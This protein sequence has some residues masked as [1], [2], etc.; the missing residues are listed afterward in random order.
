M[1]WLLTVVWV[2]RLGIYI[3]SD[4]RWKI[5]CEMYE[6]THSELPSFFTSGRLER[7]CSGTTIIQ[8]FEYRL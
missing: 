3:C 5:L 8:F 6:I 7:D 2:V 4:F 1:K